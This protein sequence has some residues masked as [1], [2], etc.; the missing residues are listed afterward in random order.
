ME[1]FAIGGRMVHWQVAT[2]NTRDSLM[3]LNKGKLVNLTCLHSLKV[4]LA[5]FLSHQV[6]AKW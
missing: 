4:L 3:V 5:R 2:S 6:G 1:N